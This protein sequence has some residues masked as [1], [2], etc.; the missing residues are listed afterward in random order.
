M[1]STFQN[2]SVDMEM[3]VIKQKLAQCFL[4]LCNIALAVTAIGGMPAPSPSGP[5]SLGGCE[6]WKGG[7]QMSASGSTVAET[8]TTE[9]SESEL[10]N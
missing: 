6:L 10:R 7:G 9:E 5:C 8:T 3:K 2:V 1:P 4:L